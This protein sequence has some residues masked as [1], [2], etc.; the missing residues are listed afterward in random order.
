M[1]L[2]IKLGFAL[3]ETWDLKHIKKYWVFK[4]L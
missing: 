2:K 1:I 4:I 3:L